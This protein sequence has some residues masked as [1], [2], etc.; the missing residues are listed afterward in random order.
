MR[1]SASRIPSAAP[2]NN[3][4]V[5]ILERADARRRRDEVRPPRLRFE[6]RRQRPPREPVAKLHGATATVVAATSIHV[7]ARGGPP[8]HV[9][10]LEADGQRLFARFDPAS[11]DVVPPD[12]ELAGQKVRVQIS[13]DGEQTFQLGVRQGFGFGRFVDSLRRRVG[14]G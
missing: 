9:A 11:A 12:L 2:G 5:T 1:A 7:T 3:N 8:L 10:L 14:G 4:Y 13:A 6:S